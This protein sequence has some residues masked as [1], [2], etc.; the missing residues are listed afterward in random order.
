[1]KIS[2][3]GLLVTNSLKFYF[4]GKFFLVYTHLQVILLLIIV[5]LLAFPSFFKI[6]F[7]NF[8]VFYFLQFEFYF[9]IIGFLKALFMF[10]GL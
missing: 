5:C 9:L 8:F 7:E 4:S 3:I 1:M 6:F 2:K 10:S